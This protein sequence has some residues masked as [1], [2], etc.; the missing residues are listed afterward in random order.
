MCVIFREKRTDIRTIFR[1]PGFLRERRSFKNPGDKTSAGSGQPRSFAM[2]V[3]ASP[4]LPRCRD[5]D[6]W[7]SDLRKLAALARRDRDLA[8]G[9]NRLA[10][11]SAP[12]LTAHIDGGTTKAASDHI[13][14]YEIADRSKILLTTAIAR[15]GDAEEKNWATHG[16]FP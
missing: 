7:W 1:P 9:F 3:Q 4:V 6:V 16:L 14:P 8:Q 11:E 15:H 10:Q 2:G 5:D 12:L 13:V